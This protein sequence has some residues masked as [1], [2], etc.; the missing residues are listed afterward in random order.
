[1]VR[2]FPHPEFY[3]T[4]LA[5]VSPTKLNK[6]AMWLAG[7]G[8]GRDGDGNGFFVSASVNCGNVR[9]TT[10]ILPLEDIFATFCLR[11][12]GS[13]GQKWGW[14]SLRIFWAHLKTESK[15]TLQG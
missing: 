3:M 15:T 11:Q 9:I 6:G 1:M 7:L 8:S 2:F 10:D 13:G 4:C 14:V 5:I 12:V